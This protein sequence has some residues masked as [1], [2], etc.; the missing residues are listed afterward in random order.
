MRQ[1]VEQKKKRTRPSDVANENATWEKAH[2]IHTDRHLYTDKKNKLGEELK[3]E[4]E[5]NAKT[6]QEKL[7]TFV[8]VICI[9]QWLG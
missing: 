8:Q 9:I 6:L 7:G 2:V 4:N 5:S 1:L 3:R